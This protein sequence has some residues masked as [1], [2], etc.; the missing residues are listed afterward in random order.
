MRVK[1]LLAVII[2]IM[3]VMSYPGLCLAEDNGFAFNINPGVYFGSIS[4]SDADENGFSG[5]TLSGYDLNILTEFGKAF[6][7]E[8]DYKNAS[9]LNAV[10]SAAA[11]D[12]MPEDYIPEE[13]GKLDNRIL[14]AIFH[15]RSFGIG[16]M[17]YDFKVEETGFEELR[18]YQGILIEV[19]HSWQ[20]NPKRQIYGKVQYANL[21]VDDSGKRGL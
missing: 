16:L 5:A 21:D 14:T 8:I 6:D 18:S 20:V 4:Y 13:A 10:A 9:S 17:K 11:W 12:D 19:G 3:L 15:Y 1:T 7:L 2:G